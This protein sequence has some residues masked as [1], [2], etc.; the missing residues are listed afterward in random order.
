MKYTSLKTNKTK[1]FN[2]PL[3]AGGVNDT[4]PPTEIED[5]QL[6]KG[7]N[8]WNEKG[9]INSRPGIY[10]TVQDVLED[11]LYTY[12]DKRDFHITDTVF[13]YEGEYQK[14]AYSIAY[15]DT[16][17]AFLFVFLIG[18]DRSVKNIGN[19]YFA[20]V[21]DGLFY[22]PEKVTFFV[23]KAQKGNGIYAFISLKNFDNASQKS[24]R[25]YEANAQLDGW[26]SVDSFYTPTVLINGR[27]NNYDMAKDNSEAYEGAP[28]ALEPLNMLDPQFYAYFTSDG[29]SSAFRLPF[30]NIENTSVICRLYYNSDEYVQWIIHQDESS[31]EINFSGQ[32]ITVSVDREKGVIHF[33]RLG[34][35]YAVPRYSVYSENN[36]RILATKK[37]DEGFKQVISCSCSAALGSRILLSGGI[38]KN[39]VY[40]SKFENPLYFP[41]LENNEI[42][43]FESRVTALFSVGNF[44]LAY[45]ENE[46]YKITLKKGDAIST[47]A[48]VADRDTLFYKKDKL[49]IECISKN[50]GCLNPLTIAL[51]GDMPVWLSANGSIYGLKNS[52]ICLSDNIKALDKADCKTAVGGVIG[53]HYV[54]CYGADAIIMEYKENKAAFYYWQ[55]PE[56]LKAIGIVGEERMSIL[57]ENCNENICFL[58][59]LEGKEDVIISRA[60]SEMITLPSEILSVIKTKSYHLGSFS[61]KK[62]I[63]N[64]CLQLEAPGETE[65]ILGAG[66]EIFNEYRFEECDFS[67]KLGSYKRIA[68]DFAGVNFLDITVKT[69]KGLRFA[70]ADIYYSESD[71]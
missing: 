62:L 32:Q 67:S 42:G 9:V 50:I 30:A 38:E 53:N 63:K 70:A 26:D 12:L 31:S 13:Y 14:I 48:L 20:R 51:C 36:I 28:T 22:C 34:G 15:S 2:I 39:K 23:G 55:F 18:S 43:S 5:N 33:T 41:R 69:S 45:K 40:Y 7:L 21:T 56:E 1:V 10:S 60:L 65:V 19:I 49:S 27:G 44:A 54:L 71:F 58:A 61:K 37:E 8:I 3:A 6:V 46:L 35:D 47:N 4:L 57:F 66:D 68:L 64:I 52:V 11:N 16:T 25:V 59:S 29:Y 24:Y 17:N